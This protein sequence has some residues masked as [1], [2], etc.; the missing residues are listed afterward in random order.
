MKSRAIIGE[1]SFTGLRGQLALV[2]IA[3]GAFHLAFVDRVLAPVVLIYLSCLIELTR[4]RRAR[5]AFYSGLLLGF[6]VFAPRLSFF[7]TIFGLAA[8][9]L[10]LVL[11]FWH[12]LFV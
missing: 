11:A 1:A 12:G 10:W 6:L 3:A 7:Y 5:L 8:V 4:A 9:P 2:V